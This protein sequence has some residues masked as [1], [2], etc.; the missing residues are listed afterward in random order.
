[1]FLNY[2]FPI[3]SK[4]ELAHIFYPFHGYLVLCVFPKI[5]LRPWRHMFSKFL[6]N[7]WDPPGFGL[8]AYVLAVC[9]GIFVHFVVFGN[10]FLVKVNVNNV[11]NRWK[12]W[13]ECDSLKFLFESSLSFHE[14]S[15]FVS[16]LCM[17]YTSMCYRYQ[18]S[19]F[20]AV[21]FILLLSIIYLDSFTSVVLTCLVLFPSIAIFCPIVFFCFHLYIAWS[22]LEIK[23]FIFWAERT[24]FDCCTIFW[25]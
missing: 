12:L 3:F 17:M 9:F 18:N 15:Y 10:M 20:S 8:G 5:I 25:V 11:W 21:I 24:I 19:E 16:E 23:Q 22:T 7:T 14:L 4:K 6:K 2:V 1:M 13:V